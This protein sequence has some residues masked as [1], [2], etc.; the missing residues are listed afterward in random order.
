[1]VSKNKVYLSSVLNIFVYHFI[2]FSK[3]WFLVSRSIKLVVG[4]ISLVE[5]KPPTKVTRLDP[6]QEFGPN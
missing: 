6:Q 2:L 1:M 4:N 3:S 5:H